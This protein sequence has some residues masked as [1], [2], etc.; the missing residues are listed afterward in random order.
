M[1]DIR[2][3]KPALY[4]LLLLGFTGFALAG[5]SPAVW[6]LSVGALALNA[7]LIRRG[8]FKPMPRLL[9]NLITI[10]ALLYVI[11]D[12]FTSPTTPVMVIGQF[13]VLLQVVK[14]WEQR[15]NR[16]YAQLLVLSLLL[17]VA[18]SINTASLLFGM[19][20][21]AYLF[22]SLYCC[23]LFHLK[24]ET[25]AAKT[26]MALPEHKL[27]PA[28]LRQDQRHLTRSMRRLTG[29]VSAV[30][31]V[32]AVAVFLFFPRGTGAGLLGPMQI[33]PAQ[34]LVGFSNEV[35]FEN[36]ARIQQNDE[37]IAEVQLSHN[38]KP[39][40]WAGPLLLRGVT[41]DTYTGRNG[42]ARWHWTR[43]RPGDEASEEY[44]VERDTNQLLPPTPGRAVPA[45]LPADVGL[46]KQTVKLHPTGTN[47]LF[48]MGGPVSFRPRRNEKFHFS[49]GDGV[50]E[51]I[52]PLLD[53]IEYEVISSNTLGNAP[54]ERPTASVID[55][56][57]EEYARR[58]QVSGEDSSGPLAARRKKSA[59]SGPDPLDEQIAAN[60]EKHLKTSFTYTLDLTDT[61]RIEGR[62]PLVAFLYDFK[63]GHCEYF[64]GAMTLM[65]QSLGLTARMVVG[66]HCD[67]YNTMG[68]YYIVR[69]SHAH[70]WVE[71]LT[72][73]GWKTFD[74]TSDRDDAEHARQAGVWQNVRHF[75]D[76][77][78]YNYA[79]SV[80][81]YSNDDR[82]NLIQAAD[83][84]MSKLAVRS[85]MGLDAF[86]RHG[87]RDPRVFP[88]FWNLSSGV[89]ASVMGLVM[90]TGLAF[91]IRFAW[92]KW[93]LRRRAHRIG[94]D[95]LPPDEQMRLA[96]QL[97]FY[98]DLLQLLGRHQIAR[99][100]HL[101][102]LEFSRS[103][104]FL[105]AGAYE[106][107]SRLTELFYRVRFGRAELS[108]ARRKRLNTV[109]ERLEAELAAGTGA[110]GE[111]KRGGGVGRA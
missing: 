82:T 91:I 47:V 69:Q 40:R 60:I 79:N 97:G 53:M 22:L 105:S 84:G 111:A 9:S 16:D 13:L 38:G 41:L 106:T 101:T 25:D 100:R 18:A 68:D 37:K 93:Q 67:E 48:A 4:F 56:Q 99:P 39:A 34:P 73:D 43:S 107:V 51:S 58:P 17:M 62:D 95:S 83:T 20:L 31:I 45:E 61:R 75:F 19:L 5:Q 80:I 28:M 14:L 21:L 30:A 76:Y 65:C 49:P 10:V 55:P 50:L 87:L 102:P 3:F 29:L 63:K 108:P 6:V 86:R 94:I 27:S 71:V 1:Y 12:V 98:D 78:E 15:G 8:R 109:I 57:I 26:A 11:R 44:V 88:L 7:W 85:T 81:A 90:A 36:I 77:L 32:F 2:Q 96:R 89:L 24:V 74:P 52:D 64:A 59:A 103:L 35:G 72:P 104:L 66:F 42:S 54:P 33:R 92:E 70:A 46:W 110:N 23:L